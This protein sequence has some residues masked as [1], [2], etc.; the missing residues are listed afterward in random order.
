MSLPPKSVHV[1]LSPECH[2]R[3]RLMADVQGVEIA[4]L[5][6]ALLTEAVMGKFHTLKVAGD[7]MVASGIV[8]KGRE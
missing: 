6:E 8:G 1:R 3:V 5:C 4:T 7:R 2:E